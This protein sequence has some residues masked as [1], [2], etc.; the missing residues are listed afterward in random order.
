[1]LYAE[2]AFDDYENDLEEDID[3][4]G[5]NDRNDDAYDINA[6]GVPLHPLAPGDFRFP[7]RRFFAKLFSLLPSFKMRRRHIRLDGETLLLILRAAYLTN[8]KQFKA[9]GPLVDR[10][11][12]CSSV[13][14]KIAEVFEIPSDKNGNFAASVLTDGFSIILPY[15]RD[16]NSTV[17]Q[18]RPSPPPSSYSSVPGKGFAPCGKIRISIAKREKAPLPTSTPLSPTPLPS[19]SS[20]SSHLQHLRL[21]AVDPG[22]SNL[23]TCFEWLK[24]GTYHVWQLSRQDWRDATC[25]DERLQ[26]SR[27]FCRNLKSSFAILGDPHVSAKTTSLGQFLRHIHATE[28]VKEVIFTETLRSRWADQVFLARQRKSQAL[29]LFWQKV[30][31]GSIAD[32]TAG[33]TPLFAYGDA[34]FSGRGT[35]TTA[36]VQACQRNVGM[37]NFVLTDE[38]R[39]TI[40]CA[41]CGWLLHEVRTFNS[42]KKHDALVK[43]RAAI[44]ASR[45]EKEDPNKV[46]PKN[47]VVRG[48]KVCRNPSCQ[49]K[50]SSLLDRDVNPCKNMILITQAIDAG[51]PVPVNL[52]R[53]FKFSAADRANVRRNPFYINKDTSGTLKLPHGCG[54]A[55]LST[56][57]QELHEYNAQTTAWSAPLAG[58]VKE[59]RL[60]LPT[61]PSMGTSG[62]S[63]WQAP[64]WP[65]DKIQEQSRMSV[66][67]SCD[68]RI[69]GEQRGM[70]LTAAPRLY[71]PVGQLPLK[72]IEK[73]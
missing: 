32:G 15:S 24:D 35:P 7:G 29:D 39:S 30:I 50:H 9:L 34:G 13:A 59:T 36:M 70:S 14:D 64:L 18:G 71:L 25:A 27:K 40:C 52:T 3:E 33:I 51:L 54:D 67:K 46:P 63:R 10:L 41:S 21:I 5:N 68:F 11:R 16:L 49:D 66:E 1:M 57:R 60:L 47:W 58:K 6:P 53:S 55:T 28:S 65:V 42:S 26:T 56:I 17:R 8:E 37:V 20:Q 73:K 22:I 61:R 72:V 2:E 45:G 19:S 48:L 44:L 69:V 31:A 12:M 43:K 4:D 38:F 23:V 62:A